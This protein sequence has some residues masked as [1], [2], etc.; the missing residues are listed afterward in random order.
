MAI[1]KL[2]TA[3]A[4]ALGLAAAA[5][6]SAIIVG[7][8][9]FGALGTT[10]HIE[11]ADLAETYV[12]GV[13]QTLQG[14]GYINKVNG[15]TTYCADNTSNC[16]LYYYFHDYTVQT[17]DATT[18]KV[19][20]TGG[21][22]DIYYSGSSSI[23]LLSQNSTANVATIQGLTPWVQLT[24]HS[25]FDPVFAPVPTQTLNGI[26]TLTGAT[27]SE[28]GFGL[29]DSNAGFGMA[30]VTSYLNGNSEGDNLGGF[31]D[32]TVTTSSNNSVLN[33]FDTASSLA[34]SCKTNPQPGDWCLQGTLNTRGS[35]NLVPEP[36]TLALLG[37]GLLGLGFTQR[38]R[39]F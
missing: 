37:V 31:A 35:T 36:A 18:G 15:D 8:I 28:A 16:G 13:G 5:P 17:F 27:L 34:D 2:I 32:V 9:D 22:V 20:F 6:A 7:G 33:P 10:Q 1:K 19:T 38:K 26:G 3:V 21:I 29:L 39:W 30:A 4:A 14:Y 12:N 25:F 24:G 23:N 11:T